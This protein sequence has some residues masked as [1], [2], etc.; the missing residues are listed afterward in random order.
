M[1]K[2]EEKAEVLNSFFP[3]GFNSETSCVVGFDD[4]KLLFQPKQLMIL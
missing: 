1:T 4:L 2:N 3:S